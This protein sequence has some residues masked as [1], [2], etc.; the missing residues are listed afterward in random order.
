MCEEDEE[1]EF[2]EDGGFK[3]MYGFVG[4]TADAKALSTDSNCTFCMQNES[5][6]KSKKKVEVE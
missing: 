6:I 5:E 2:D 3:S 1:D 4:L